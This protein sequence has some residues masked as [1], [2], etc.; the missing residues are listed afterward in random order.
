MVSSCVLLKSLLHSNLLFC[1]DG[2][3]FPSTKY[4]VALCTE[5]LKLDRA[6]KKNVAQ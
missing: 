2:D 1:V 4:Q 5:N 6:V 3:L